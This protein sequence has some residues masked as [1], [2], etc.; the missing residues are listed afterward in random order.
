[1][2]ARGKFPISPAL[3]AAHLRTRAPVT[4]DAFDSLLSQRA[5]AHSPT[6]WTPVHVAQAAARLFREAGATRVLD[7]GS[8]VGKF[9]TILSLDS[10]HRVWG[11]ERRGALVYES[12]L[13]AQQL[14]AEVVIIEGALTDVDPRPFDGFYFFNP[15]AEHL[16]QPAFCFDVEIERSLEGHLREARCIEQWLNDA[17][18]GT[19]FVTYNGLGG[20]I[21]TSFMA[22]RTLQLHGNVMRLWV[23]VRETASDAFIDI[24]DL[25]LTASYLRGLEEEMGADFPF[26]RNPLVRALM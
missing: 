3:L 12:R 13:L 2:T 18:V 24:E 6:F 25:L 23:K 5:S 17:P 10:G 19:C 14:E 22:R 4:D 8:G 16:A 9:C 26:A 15:L 21:P 11:V 1:M 20:R 7:V